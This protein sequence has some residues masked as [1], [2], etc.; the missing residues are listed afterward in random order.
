MRIVDQSISKGWKD[1]YP[2]KEKFRA[3]AVAKQFTGETAKDKDGKE[4]VY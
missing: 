1:L 4:I 3:G 2:L